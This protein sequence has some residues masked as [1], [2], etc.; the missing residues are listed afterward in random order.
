MRPR[1]MRFLLRAAVLLLAAMAPSCAAPR[2]AWGARLADWVMAT[3]PNPWEIHSGGWEYNAGIVLY[4]MGQIYR[5]TGEARYFEYI[6]RWVDHFV[7]GEGHLLLEGPPNLDLIQPG[8]VL[9]LVYEETGEARYRL[10]AEEL[11]ARLRA[12]PRNAVGGFWHKEIY[13]QEM[14]VDGLYMAGP[15]CVRYA[16]LFGPNDLCPDE[17]VRQAVLLAEH[18]QDPQTGLL[19][20]AWDAD[21]S[22]PW[23]DPVTGLSPEVWGRG[24]GWYTMALVEMLQDLPPEHPGREELLG[25]LRWAARG[26]EA[27]QDPHTGL[28]H[29]VLGKGSLPDN[30]LETSA[31]AMFVYALKVGA[32]R[33]YLEARYERIAR[34]GW[35]GLQTKLRLEADGTPRVLDAVEGMGV[36]RDYAAYVSKARLTNS[37]HGLAAAMLAASVMEYAR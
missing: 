22:A 36:Q 11:L 18:A 7:D 28:W 3:W 37:T 21:A 29:Q 24:M 26:L 33:G 1:G 34:R 9:L 27:T 16:R 20:H 12:H 32:E 19:R 10:A 30:W 17:A 14:W 5:R 25:I 6:R 15:F 13:P 31:S 4:G 35:R 2:P 23:A 8:M